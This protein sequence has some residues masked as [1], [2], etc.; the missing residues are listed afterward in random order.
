MESILFDMMTNQ[1]V[2]LDEI[3]EKVIS[4]IPSKQNLRILDYRIYSSV[5]DNLGSIKSDYDIYIIVEDIECLDLFHNV[6]HTIVNDV[7]LD[8]Q[9]YSHDNF[10]RIINN[11]NKKNYRNILEMKLILKFLKAIKI[12][13]SYTYDYDDRIDLKNIKVNA[14]DFFYNH[15]INL[16]NDSKYMMNIDD[17]R[18]ALLMSY[19]SLHSAI[20]MLNIANNNLVLK[21]KWI[22]TIFSNNN[23]YIEGF[24]EKFDDLIMNQFAQ[25]TEIVMKINEINRFIQEIISSTAFVDY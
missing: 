11:V 24:K 15:A 7:H 10:L 1:G 16:L 5:L 25:N 19:E 9:V 18:G 17:Y 21:S 23:G 22:M 8:I 6:I 20:A 13:S 12:E 4:E 2:S 3:R 14:F